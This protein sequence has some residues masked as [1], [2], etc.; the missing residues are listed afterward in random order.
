MKFAL[1]LLY[2]GISPQSLSPLRA[3]RFRSSFNHSE[4]GFPC[5]RGFG[6][7]DDVEFPGRESLF[8][9]TLSR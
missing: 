6:A 3:R 9:G 5:F 2:H 1:L 4:T 7:A 8:C